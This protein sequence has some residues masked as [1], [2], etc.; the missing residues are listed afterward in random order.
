MKFTCPGCYREGEL[1]WQL[2]AAPTPTVRTAFSS[3]NANNAFNVSGGR[4]VTD[5]TVPCSVGCAFTPT[6]GGKLAQVEI[7][8]Y[9]S[10]MSQTLEALRPIQLWEADGVGQLGTM[11]TSVTSMLPKTRA[12]GAVSNIEKVII[13]SPSVM[14]STEKLYWLVLAH[15]ATGIVKDVWNL[16]LNTIGNCVLTK[17]GGGWSYFPQSALCAFRIGVV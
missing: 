12:P 1:T 16:S 15:T 6:E 10:S 11:L 9:R 3:F 17:A 2:A 8:I 7:A 13:P 5:G 4:A 14:L